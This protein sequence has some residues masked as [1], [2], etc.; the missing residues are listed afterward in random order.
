MEVSHPWCA[1]LDVHKDNV[2]ACAR[3]VTEKGLEQ[4]VQTFAPTTAGLL[5]L[6][7]WL[8]SFGVTHI[9]IE[10]TRVCSTSSFANAR[11][12]TVRMSPAARWTS[13][14]RCGSPTCS[15]PAMPQRFG[16]PQ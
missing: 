7:D 8:A 4:Q 16:P 11:H 12:I 2:V 10:A 9:A 13:T 6:S 15:P 14:T 5:K 3:I 1:G